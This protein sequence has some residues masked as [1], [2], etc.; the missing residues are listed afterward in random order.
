M[1]EFVS[2]IVENKDKHF[3]YR[4]HDIPDTDRL[5]QLADFIE[6]LGYRLKIDEDGVTQENMNKLL[7]AVEGTPEEAMI[8][9]AA[10]RTM[11]KATYSMKNIGHYGLAFKHYA[12]FTSPIRRYPDIMVHRLLDHYIRGKAPSSKLLEEYHR[13]AE[14]ATER[15]VAAQE[16]ERESIR[17]KQI[18]Y[19]SERIGQSYDGIISGLSKWGIYVQEQETLSEGMVRLADL[20]DDFYI[21]DE[22]NYAMVGKDSGRRYRLGDQVKIK[23]VKADLKDKVIDFEFV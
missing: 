4:V 16:A 9:T 19:M 12:H 15:E 5:K 13:L 3:V 20:S 17:Y 8:H 21:F 18:E 2:K 22:K 1:A 23:V 6:P 14:H 11:S 10:L 7:R